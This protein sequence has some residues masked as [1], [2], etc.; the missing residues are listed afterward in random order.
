MPASTRP[1]PAAPAAGPPPFAVPPLPAF[2]AGSTLRAEDLNA[3]MARLAAVHALH[4]RTMH[5]RG[6][7]AGL[8]VSLEADGATL[9][10]GA[11]LAIDALGIE[12][13]LDAPVFV[14]PPADAKLGSAVSSILALAAGDAGDGAVLVWRSPAAR[15]GPSRLVEGRDVVLARV[16]YAGGKVAKIDPASRRDLRPPDLRAGIT[17]DGATEWSLWVPPDEGAV[18]KGVATFV[19]W[20]GGMESPGA[21]P[22]LLAQ[23]VGDRVRGGAIVLDGPAFVASGPDAEGFLFVV[24]FPEEGAAAWGAGSRAGQAH[25]LDDLRHVQNWRVAWIAIGTDS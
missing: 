16:D 11:G 15:T 12:R 6:I 1:V 24:A 14:D 9:R 5:P 2:R 10:V 17:P 18:P 25:L 20:P 21:P 8:G 23:L 13:V 22:V 19:R 7:V 3:S 4:N